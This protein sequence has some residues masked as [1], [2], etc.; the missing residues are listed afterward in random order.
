MSVEFLEI[1]G[2]G[3]AVD[4]PT[5]SATVASLSTSTRSAG[6]GEQYGVV[7]V[8]VRDDLGGAVGGA[9]VT[10]QLSGSFGGT[11]SGTTSSNG[12]VVLT[13]AVTAKKPSF[14]ACVES[15]SGAQLLHYEK[16]N[17]SCPPSGST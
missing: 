7:T 5:A 6:R 1:V 3:D 11:L 15:I 8:Q 17:E 12:N 10:V 4:P 16:G 13:T 2:D 9:T 14:S